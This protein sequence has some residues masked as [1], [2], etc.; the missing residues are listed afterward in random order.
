M[1]KRSIPILYSKKEDCCGCAACFA[2]CPQS[3]IQIYDDEEGFQYPQ[4]NETSCIQCGLCMRVCP[5]KGITVVTVI[6][7]E[8]R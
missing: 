5:L 3:A 2:I 6:D 8:E 4:I 7:C 1:E